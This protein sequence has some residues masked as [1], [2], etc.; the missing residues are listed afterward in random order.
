MRRTHMV[1]IGLLVASSSLSAFG[2][3]TD[4]SLKPR[5][6]AFLASLQQPENPIEH[7][8]LAPSPFEPP[9]QS[10]VAPANPVQ[11]PTATV[12]PNGTVQHGNAQ[13]GT[14]PAVGRY[15]TQ[16]ATSVPYGSNPTPLLDLMTDDPCGNMLWRSYRYQAIC[17]QSH[18][19]RF[20]HCGPST[21]GTYGCHQCGGMQPGMPLQHGMAAPMQNPG[22]ASC[23]T[24]LAGPVQAYPPFARQAPIPMP[25]NQQAAMQNSGSVPAVAARPNP[26]SGGLAPAQPSNAVFR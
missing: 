4:G 12:Y 11:V 6:R 19:L 14:A 15:A 7:D 2:Q 17:E 16:V 1:A 10:I 8:D 9:F 20:L 18:C 22:C 23:S 26:R 13:L 21:C 24:H 25:M 5:Q 3:G